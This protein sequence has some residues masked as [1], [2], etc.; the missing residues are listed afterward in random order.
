MKVFKEMIMTKKAVKR[1]MKKKSQLK[2]QA[3]RQQKQQRIIQPVG[4]RYGHR[5]YGNA[6]S[7][8]LQLRNQNQTSIDYINSITS[9][10]W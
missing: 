5:Q 2:K 8:L 10:F 7:T 4:L 9:A 1:V 3:K 6:D